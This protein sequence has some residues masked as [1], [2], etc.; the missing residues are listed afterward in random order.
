MDMKNM[1]IKN[2]DVNKMKDSAKAAIAVSQNHLKNLHRNLNRVYI[3]I[4]AN[5]NCFMHQLHHAIE[6]HHIRQ[7]TISV[8]APFL[9]LMLFMCYMFVTAPYGLTDDGKK[10]EEPFVIKAGAIELAVVESADAAE[11]VIASFQQSY[12]ADGSEIVSF[13]TEPFLNIAKKDMERAAGPVNV[14]SQP[15]A[16]NALLSA[17]KGLN[18]MMTATLTEQLVRGTSIAHKVVKKKTDDLT[19]GTK[20]VETKGVDGKKATVLR[21]T[22]VNG[23]VTASTEIKETVLKKPVTEVVLIGTKPAPRVSYSYSFSGSTISTSGKAIA[24]TTGSDVVA[25]A[26]RF[27]GNP[28]QYGGTSL[29]NGTDC[30]GFTMGVYAHFG[31]YLPHS[32]YAQRSYGTPIS[33]SEARPGDLLFYSGHVA[34][35]IGGGKIIHASTERT[36]IIIGSATYRTILA[37]RRIL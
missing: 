26:K 35:Y 5:I 10:V 34:I 6:G 16:V 30:S 3:E 4:I 25:Y 12:L 36:G 19:V 14:V 37:V 29:T 15:E 1:R 22:K 32:S 17:C 21:V 2:M 31:V 7:K 11:Q 23:E 8:M 13:D 9:A 33:Y 24:G 28:Y 18:P 20:K 27:L